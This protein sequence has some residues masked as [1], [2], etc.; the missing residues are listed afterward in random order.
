MLG[1]AKLR[2]VSTRPRSGGFRLIDLEGRG[3]RSTIAPA[4]ALLLSLL[5]TVVATVGVATMSRARDAARFQHAVDGARDRITARLEGYATLLRAG[6]AFVSA[7][8]AVTAE[9]FEQFAERFRLEELYPGI[10]GIGLTVR[11][12]PEQRDS[13]IQAQRTGRFPDFRIWPEAPPREELHSIVYLFPLDHRNQ[14]AIGYD[15]FSEAVRREA[16]S[17][18]RDAGRSALSGRVTLVQEI[19]GQPQAGFLL[20]A[21]VYRLGGI[22]TTVDARRE[23]LSGFV[24]APFRADD[25]FS[26]I[27]GSDAA[28][29]V[30]FTVY[31]GEGI[32]PGGLLHDSAVQGIHGASGREHRAVARLVIAGRPWTVV[33]VPTPDFGAESRQRIWLIM[34]VLGLA[35]S[36]VLYLVTRRE[37]AARSAAESLADRVQATR[38][39]LER[40]VREVWALNQEIERANQDLA[41]ANRAL[42]GTNRELVDLRK[43]A[44]AARDEAHRAN[45]IK[46]DFLAAMSHELRTPLNAIMGYADLLDLGIHGPVTPQQRQ[47]LERIRRSQ[48]HLL[49]LINDILNYAK[50]EAGRVE[51]RREP[52]PVSQ[53][54]CDLQEMTEPQAR[55]RGHTVTFRAEEGDLTACADADK[56]RQVLLNLLAN[57]IK[58]TSPGGHIRVSCGGTA[59]S[60]LIRVEDNGPGIAADR[61]D[62][63]FDPFVQVDRTGGRDGQ[64]GVGLGLAISRDLAL[65]M[66]GDLSVHSEPGRGSVFLLELPRAD[67]DSSDGEAQGVRRNSVRKR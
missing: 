40:Q 44:D 53:M 42:L 35:A 1:L 61:L 36:L 49:G 9:E 29:Q 24:Y 50:I 19:E 31:D 14:A 63:I 60:V 54:L 41:I 10:Q 2:D 38:G 5:L 58:F 32:D 22:P 17:T 46:S 13:L 65:L 4:L 57:A 67:A 3:R 11:I 16:M 18:A 34:L 51:V 20:Y 8:E 59:D 28:P 30:A 7:S 45:Q 33:F 47:A 37:A 12:R 66:D 64:H 15:M 56:V 39:E 21:P 25:L 6:A 27:F 52:V 26:G 62:T 43:E 55:E 23:E 48:N